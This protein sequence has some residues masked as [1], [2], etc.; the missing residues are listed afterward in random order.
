M[1]LNQ[2]ILII[3]QLITSFYFSQ[4]IHWSQTNQLQAFENP[5]CIDD[6]DEE[7]KFTFAARDQWRSV[8][9]PFQTFLF[10]IETKSRKYNWLSLGCN[11]FNDITGDGTFKTNAVNFILELEKKVNNQ[12]KISLGTTFGII[13]KNIDFTNFKFDNQYDGFKYTKNLPTKENFSNSNF[14]NLNLGIGISG[15][16]S[17]N[18][19]SGLNFGISL[20]NLVNQ[21]ESF[22]QFE[23]IRPIRNTVNLNYIRKLKKH[24]FNASI[25]FQ[26]Q[27]KYR[28]IITGFFDEYKTQN[29]KFKSF[30]GGIS[31]RMLDAFIVHT[32][33]FLKNT[34]IIFSY[35]LNI[36]KLKTASKGRG[37]LEI[38]IQYLIK[39]KEINLQLE[40]TCLDYF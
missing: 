6:L 29:T 23:I 26:K 14:N 27:Q 3:S 19:F 11:F 32:G 39:K 36:S 1:R 30:Y 13:N 22:Y 38:N 16:Y 21:K 35:D 7:T 10:S 17:F 34:K 31:Y 28:E 40:K 5:S 12:F 18:K 15:S 2:L 37:S 33:F 9:K 24:Q 4:D 25:F 20:N 8:T